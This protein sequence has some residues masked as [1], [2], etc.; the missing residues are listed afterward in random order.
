MRIGLHQNKKSLS[1]ECLSSFL[2]LITPS[3]EHDPIDH[4]TLYKVI[5]AYLVAKT[6]K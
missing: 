1:N 3:N 5:F 6:K 2:F 4:F